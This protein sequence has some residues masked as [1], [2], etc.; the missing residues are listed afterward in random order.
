MKNHLNLAEQR[1]AGENMTLRQA[2]VFSIFMEHGAGISE[3]A[4]HYIKEKL[5]MINRAGRPEML[6][7]FAG[8]NKFVE[9]L[10]LWGIKFDE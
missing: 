10:E 5:D 1:K 6:L 4:P 3:K 9:W 2:V 7:D 8:F